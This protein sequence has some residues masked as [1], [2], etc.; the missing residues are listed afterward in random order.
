VYVRDKDGDTWY[1]QPGALVNAARLE[2]RAGCLHQWLAE[3]LAHKP[4]IVFQEVF[5]GPE[6]GVEELVHV[7]RI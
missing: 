4:T 2:A 3:Q 1:Y 5:S 7:T 6:G